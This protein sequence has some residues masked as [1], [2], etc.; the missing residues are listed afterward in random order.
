MSSTNLKIFLI[1]VSLYRPLKEVITSIKK[2][3]LFIL[4]FVFENWSYNT[5]SDILYNICI[6]ID[7]RLSANL[8]LG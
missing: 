3:N 8:Y 6:V 5:K 1:T 7:F 4:N 2:I